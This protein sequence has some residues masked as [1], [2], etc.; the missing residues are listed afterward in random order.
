MSHLLSHLANIFLSKTKTAPETEHLLPSSQNNLSTPADQRMLIDSI[1]HQL[2]SER[3]CG[4]STS[5]LKKLRN[6]IKQRL[7]KKPQVGSASAL[8]RTQF[9]NIDAHAN[10]VETNSGSNNI[11]RLQNIDVYRSQQ[12]IELHILLQSQLRAVD[13]SNVDTGD[14]VIFN[15]NT[16]QWKPI[17][18]VSETKKR[19]MATPERSSSN[20]RFSK[21]TREKLSRALAATAG[22]SVK[23]PVAA[24][25]VASVN[26]AHTGVVE[27]SDILGNQIKRFSAE[28]VDMQVIN[29]RLTTE[30]H[31]VKEISGAGANCWW[32]CGMFAAI[33]QKTPADLEQIIGSLGPKFADHAAAVAQ[34]A[35]AVHSQGP[36]A[37]QTNMT[38]LDCQ[39]DMER[40]SRI[41]LGGVSDAE[42]DGRGEFVCQEVVNALLERS[43]VPEQERYAIIYGDAQ[44]DVHHLIALMSQLESSAVIFS[45]PWGEFH[46][47]EI[48]RFDSERSSIEV[49]AQPGTELARIGADPS[50]ERGTNNLIAKLSQ[51]P[52]LIHQGGHYNF[53]NPSGNINS[54]NFRYPS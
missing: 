27:Y 9:A 1:Y 8:R 41:K 51:I 40:A 30:S 7:L 33:Q 34:M 31:R 6:T 21:L 2:D 38:M 52:F 43:G 4:S 49:C 22:A 45:K 10:N 39:T 3:P 20:T 42:D 11:Y 19:P 5:A 14:S 50:R 54:A 26:T 37:I 23:R 29:D 44:G 35:M 36:H 25:A 46:P 16:G 24:P 18:T 28:A 15:K 48:P 17:T 13:P 12:E 32:R 53:C 47:G